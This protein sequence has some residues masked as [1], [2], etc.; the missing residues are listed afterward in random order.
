MSRHS[1]T[2]R[3]VRSRITSLAAIASAFLFAACGEAAPTDPVSHA[4]GVAAAGAIDSCPNDLVRD[5]QG[6]GRAGGGRIRALGT[7]VDTSS[8]SRCR[9]DRCVVLMSTCERASRADSSAGSRGGY[10]GT[11]CTPRDR[12]DLEPIRQ[13]RGC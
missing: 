9:F 11:P 3:T 5:T 2:S 12:G 13:R 10:G 6:A 1:P 7:P 4:V 8:T